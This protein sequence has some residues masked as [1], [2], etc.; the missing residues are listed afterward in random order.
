MSKTYLCR[1]DEIS[2]QQCKEFVIKDSMPVLEIFL[3]QWNKQIYAY[4]N[5]CPHTGVTLN[6]QPDQ[7]FDITG[8]FFLCSTHG[9]MFRINDGVCV[10][11]PC[12]GASLTPLTLVFMDGAIFLET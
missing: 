11:G 8:Q 6:W 9:A 5:S 1:Q 12:V 2:E 10:H 3:T 7:F 4:K